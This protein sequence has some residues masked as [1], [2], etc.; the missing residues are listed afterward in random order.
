MNWGT[1]TRTIRRTLIVILL[2]TSLPAVV[3]GGMLSVCDYESPESRISDLGLQGSFNW[4][5]GPYADDRNRAISASVVVDYDMLSSSAAFGQAVDARGEI[6]GADA[7][8][9]ADLSGSGSLQTFF[10]DD[11]FGVG[12]VNLDAST[13]TGL[14]LDLTAGVGTGRFRNVTPLAQAIRIQND[15]LD[16]G[17]LQAPIANET[18]LDLAR[19]IGEVGPTDEEKVVGVAERLVATELVPGD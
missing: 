6:R 9:T 7:G 18:L 3:Q 1:M 8:W 14:E 15:L 4:Y 12:A 13:R 17:E 16:L 10:S 19:I 11:L 5:D 2:A